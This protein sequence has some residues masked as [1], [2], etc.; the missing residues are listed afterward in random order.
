[1]PVRVMRVRHMRM[2]M[3]YRIVSMPM[4]VCARRHQV[5]RMLVVA[6]VMRVRMLV[7]ERLMDVLM[8]VA[9][10]QMQQHAGQHQQRAGDKPHGRAALAQRIRN[11]GADERREREHRTGACGAELALRQKI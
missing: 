7:F 6:V 2:N 3:R 4:A 8:R 5:V 11:R 1:M 10:G 9:L